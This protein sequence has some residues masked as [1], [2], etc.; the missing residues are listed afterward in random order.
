MKDEACVCTKCGGA[1]ERGI[2]RYS[3]SPLME[4]NL[5]LEFV[6]L[7][8]RTSA[9]PLKAF[10]QGLTDEP[11]DRVYD[12]AKLVGDRCPACGYLELYAK[13]GELMNATP[14]LRPERPDDTNPGQIRVGRCEPRT[15]PRR[16]GATP[17]RGSAVRGRD[18]ACCGV[19]GRCIDVRRWGMMERCA[20]LDSASGR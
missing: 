2:V 3:G 14:S 12:F 16:T 4:G 11:A 10:K 18:D 6:I 17:S 1:M 9:N 19:L 13:P 7:G 8:S 15:K 5:R 20:F